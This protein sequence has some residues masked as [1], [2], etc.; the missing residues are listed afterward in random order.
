MRDREEKSHPEEGSLKE[1]K[2]R[3]SSVN[4]VDPGIKRKTGLGIKGGNL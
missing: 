3:E 2:K 4:M 1:G